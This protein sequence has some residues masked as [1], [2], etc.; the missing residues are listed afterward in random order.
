MMEWNDLY[1]ALSKKLQP[2]ELKDLLD[3]KADLDEINY[4]GIYDDTGFQRVKGSEKKLYLPKF[5]E[6]IGYVPLEPREAI[7]D[8]S[9]IVKA[10]K[11]LQE[12]LQKNGEEQEIGV[13]SNGVHSID[14]LMRYFSREEIEEID[15]TGQQ[16][17]RVMIIYEAPAKNLY[18]TAAY[19]NYSKAKN[20]EEPNNREPS[21]KDYLKNKIRR[22]EIRDC[23]T[24]VWWR[25]DLDEKAVK[26]AKEKNTGFTAMKKY[27]EFLIDFIRVFGILD[28]YTT[29]LFRYEI[30]ESDDEKF[31]GWDEVSKLTAENKSLVDSAFD[32][33]V[34]EEI[35]AYEPNVILATSKPYNYL[36][37]KKFGST[38]QNMKVEPV[39][40]LENIP[41]F[42]IPH[43]ASMLATEFRECANI[44]SVAK[45]LYKS[46][47]ITLE[48]ASNII[49]EYYLKSILENSS[50]T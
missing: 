42:K 36:W 31:L 4:K 50:E 29:N 26:E 32:K 35:K 33:I 34:I 48:K 25:M 38:K 14:L 15:T 2:N 11:K 45:E 20:Q 8:D 22:G 10:F 28:L 46:D 19:R 9:Q 49:K 47:V 23:L 24:G 43:P 37:Y 5:N 41:L 40:E 44:C 21:V 1:E 13:I 17:K 12:N 7:S 16:H 27:A 3:R 39:L 30:F 18:A 6:N